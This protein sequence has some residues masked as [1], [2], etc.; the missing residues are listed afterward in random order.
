MFKINVIEESASTRQ[1]RSDKV[2]ANFAK[3][4]E[5]FKDIKDPEKQFKFF[6]N[7]LVPTYKESIHSTGTAV[8]VCA[9][10]T[11]LF[12]G[13][14]V[15]LVYV[16]AGITA[17]VGG[18]YIRSQRRKECTRI[19]IEQIEMCDKEIERLRLAKGNHTDEIDKWEH[20]RDQLDA[21]RAETD[22]YWATD[23]IL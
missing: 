16:I 14:F 2:V 8:V 20:I 6:K 18:I 1:A 15:P 10:L 19:L 4:V 11:Q 7:K 3:I 23:I 5:E 9:W 17:N 12:I 13:A 21:A 22:T